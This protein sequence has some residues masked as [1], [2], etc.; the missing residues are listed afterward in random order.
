MLPLRFG[1]VPGMSVDARE[2]NRWV[3]EEVGATAAG[4]RNAAAK[5][6]AAVA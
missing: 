1:R 2:S 6:A 5:N 3:V 4:S